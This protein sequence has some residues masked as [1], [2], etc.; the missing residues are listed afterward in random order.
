MN[1]VI[2]CA[3][4]GCTKRVT[5]LSQIYCSKDCA[6][7]GNF[8]VAKNTKSVGP[9]SI[10]SIRERGGVSDPC[11]NVSEPKE[12]PIGEDFSTPSSAE[13]KPTGG[14]SFTM[15]TETVNANA[16]A[17]SGSTEE[18]DTDVFRT[19]NEEPAPTGASKLSYTS[20]AL[21]SPGSSA[22]T[23]LMDLI[24]PSVSIVGESS[25]SKNLIDSSIEHLHELMRSVAKEN[26]RSR[27]NPEMINAVCNCTKNL[28][29]LIKLKLDIVKAARA[30]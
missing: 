24:V 22:G 11:T 9:T 16:D 4:P 2:E 21:D 17:E 6:P 12:R 23:Q 29:D 18:W 27:T 5:Q 3:K 10:Y 1:G 28:R 8:G 7:L 25:P 14:E 26:P 30:E 15:T 20:T 19:R 13:K